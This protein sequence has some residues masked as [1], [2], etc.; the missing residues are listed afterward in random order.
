MTEDYSLIKNEIFKTFFLMVYFSTNYILLEIGNM[1]ILYFFGRLGH[2]KY[3]SISF[4]ITHFKAT[5]SC[6]IIC[7]LFFNHTRFS[8]F[9]FHLY[10]EQAIS[11][12]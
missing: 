8:N 7:K 3:E 5:G 6:L 10:H 9:H 2:I 11:K 1:T 12:I 4:E